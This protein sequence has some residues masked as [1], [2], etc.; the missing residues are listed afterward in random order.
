[1]TKID[2]GAV[3]AEGLGNIPIDEEFGTNL[4]C[5]ENGCQIRIQ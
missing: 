2:F 3:G 1:M 5:L 4:G